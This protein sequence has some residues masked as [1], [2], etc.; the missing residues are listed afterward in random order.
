MLEV[1]LPGTVI[2]RKI[3]ED[4]GFGNMMFNDNLKH[5]CASM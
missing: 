5:D 2:L 1:L 3:L 4:F